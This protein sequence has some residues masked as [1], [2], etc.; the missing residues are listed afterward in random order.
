MS[1]IRVVLDLAASLDLDV[2]QLD[3][4]TV[5]LHGDLEEEIYMEQPEGFKV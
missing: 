3:V 2:E 5:F 4:K 1:S